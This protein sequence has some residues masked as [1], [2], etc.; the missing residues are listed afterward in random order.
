MLQA[1][2]GTLTWEVLGVKHDKVTLH[3]NMENMTT[4]EACD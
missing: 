2:L 4:L 1:P 3:Q